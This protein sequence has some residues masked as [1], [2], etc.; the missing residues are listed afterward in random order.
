[1][2]DAVDAMG[3]VLSE[4]NRHGRALLLIHSA[5]TAAITKDLADAINSLWRDP[6]IQ[7]AFNCAAPSAL[8]KH[9][10]YYIESLDRVTASDYSPSNDDILRAY[11]PTQGIKEV[12]CPSLDRGTY[13]EPRWRMIEVDHNFTD[14]PKAMRRIFDAHVNDAYIFTV[15]LADYAHHGDNEER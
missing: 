5:E 10:P 11:A 3:L 14:S 15:S 13:H 8:S 9:L 2:L 7:Q 4:E 12:L 1:M 6:Y